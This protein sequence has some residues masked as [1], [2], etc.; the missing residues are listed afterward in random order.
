M[1]LLKAAA[2]RPDAHVF[3]YVL[4]KIYD[5]GQRNIDPSGFRLEIAANDPLPS[6]PARATPLIP[7]IRLFGLDRHRP[8]GRTGPD[9]WVDLQDP[10]IFDLRRGLVRFPAGMRRPF[11]ADP[12]VYEALAA[13]ATYPFS[14][15]YL[16]A[17]VMLEIYAMNTDP[18][19]LPLY[20][21]L[22]S[23]MVS[24]DA[25]RD[26]RWDAVTHLRVWFEDPTRPAGDDVV[27]LQ[28]GALGFLE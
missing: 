2:D 10:E 11:A 20:R 12:A 19:Q 17:T 15:S 4:R 6:D 14:G 9:G 13:P 7:W 27:H 23:D 8:S 22:L 3:S 16:A 21:L 25:D 28:I 18:P 24:V 26:P 1:K 5:L